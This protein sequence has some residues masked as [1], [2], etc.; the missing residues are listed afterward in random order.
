MTQTYETLIRQKVIRGYFATRSVHIGSDYLAPT[1]SLR[2][3]YH[4]PDGFN[5][6]YNGSGPAQLALAILLYFFPEMYALNTYQFFKEDVIAKLPM[7]KDFEITGGT[8]IDWSIA[9]NK[10]NVEGSANGK[11]LQDM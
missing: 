7:G 5:W 8:V 1:E 2:L 10:K 11:T 4:S 3:K 9:Y 6:G